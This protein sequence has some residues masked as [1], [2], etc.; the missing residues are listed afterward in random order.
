MKWIGL[1]LSWS[2]LYHI[3]W[4]TLHT[5][6]NHTRGIMHHHTIVMTIKLLLLIYHPI[7]ESCCWHMQFFQAENILKTSK[8][9]GWWVCFEYCSGWQNGKHQ[10]RQKKERWTSKSRQSQNTMVSIQASVVNRPL[11]LLFIIKM[12]YFECYLRVFPSPRLPN[13]CIIRGTCHL[14][15]NLSSV[16]FMCRN[17]YFLQ[18]FCVCNVDYIW[19]CVFCVLWPLE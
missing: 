10:Q 5:H 16:Y 1:I 19:N 7:I 6:S 4:N 8:R 14:A 11:N 9:R 17:S 15:L 18:I 3:Q 2:W 13:L 12:V